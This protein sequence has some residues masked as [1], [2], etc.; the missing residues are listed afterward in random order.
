MLLRSGA[1]SDERGEKERSEGGRGTQR[2]RHAV[3]VRGRK[4]EG[5]KAEDG[6]RCEC[7]PR[8][9]Y[10]AREMTGEGSS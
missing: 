2:E 5:E 6:P 4:W 3:K 9:F 7:C 10:G 1:V 8:M